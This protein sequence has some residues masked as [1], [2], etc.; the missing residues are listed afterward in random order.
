MARI[1]A[2]AAVNVDTFSLS[3]FFDNATSKVMQTGNF[4]I[5]MRGYDNMLQFTDTTPTTDVRVIAHFDNVTFSSP[6]V[7]SGGTLHSLQMQNPLGAGFTT[8]FR[9]SSID[10]SATGLMQALATSSGS[11]DRAYLSSLL[12][13][14]DSISL[15]NLA[16]RW[17][18]GAG[19]DTMTGGS[20]NDSLWGSDGNDTIDGG[21]GT[22]L[23]FGGNN[24]DR[25]IGGR[26]DDRLY[27]GDGDDFIAG[28][29]GDDEMYGGSGSDTFEFRAGD[30]EGCITS[31]KDGFDIMRVDVTNTAAPG[32][33]EV[34]SGSD[35]IVTFA[36]SDIEITLHN[37]STS[38]V[39]IEDFIFF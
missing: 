23:I 16:D 22:D 38:Q 29:T 2:T 33:T 11:D 20:G 6:G 15:G 1:T 14:A 5:G 18:S 37:K 12:S 39:G 25:I 13:G 9:I 31:F 19:N 17:S 35:V 7:V 21:I 27:G 36:G 26:S 3:Q 34:Q 8:T 10:A 32:M 28:G 30:G 24:N 4:T